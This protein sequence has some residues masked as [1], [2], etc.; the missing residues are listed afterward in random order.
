MAAI[1]A[2]EVRGKAYKRGS[3]SIGGRGANWISLRKE[4]DESYGARGLVLPYNRRLTLGADCGDDADWIGDA[5]NAPA[6][7]TLPDEPLAPQMVLRLNRVR[8]PTRGKAT[9]RMRGW[10]LPERVAN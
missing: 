10:N 4:A 3:G 8:I 5:Q 9:I 1:K 2:A 6:V 7:R